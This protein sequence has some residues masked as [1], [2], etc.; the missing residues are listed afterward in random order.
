VGRDY[1][2]DIEVTRG[3]QGWEHVVVNPS[4]VVEEGAVVVPV[5]AP[6]PRT[7]QRPGG[8]SGNNAHPVTSET[9]GAADPGGRGASVK[10]P[11]HKQ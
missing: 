1:G 6:K 2:A 7:G 8:A 9:R 4:D 10:G 3:L 11:G 5:N